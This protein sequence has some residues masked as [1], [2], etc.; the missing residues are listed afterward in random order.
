MSFGLKQGLPQLV[1][2]VGQASVQQCV[3]QLLA[4]QELGGQV[5]DGLG[6]AVDGVGLGLEPRIGEVVAHGLGDGD[7]HVG[8]SG[9]LGGDV[10]GVFQLFTNLVGEL[11]RRNGRLRCGNFGHSDFPSGI[12]A[13]A[14]YAARLVSSHKRVH[15][16]SVTALAESCCIRSQSESIT[17]LIIPHPTVCHR[18]HNAVFRGSVQG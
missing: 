2:L 12:S 3:L 14:Y 10:L 6:V 7:V 5:A 11:F 13:R 16:L 18:L 17:C 1:E 15:E 9:L 4:H 8:G